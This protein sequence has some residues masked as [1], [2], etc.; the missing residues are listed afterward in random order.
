[1]VVNDFCGWLAGGKDVVGLKGDSAVWLRLNSRA[2]L[3]LVRTFG[4]SCLARPKHAPSSR[5][6]PGDYPFTTH[7]SSPLPFEKL[8]TSSASRKQWP[9]NFARVKHAPSSRG[10]PAVFSL[11]S[12]ERVSSLCVAKEKAPRERPPQSDALRAPCPASSRS[13]C[14]VCRQSILGLTPNWLASMRATLRAFLRHF[15]AAQG[16]RLLRILSSKDEAESAH[17]ARPLNFLLPLTGR[18]CPAGRMR[19]FGFGFGAH[20]A[21]YWGPLDRGETAKEKSEGWPTRCGPVRRQSRDGLS[22]NPVAGSRTWSTGTVRKAR[23]WGGLLF[24]YFLLVTQEKV[25]RSLEASEKRQGCRA[26]KERA[27]TSQ[28]HR[29]PA[30]AGATSRMGSELPGGN[31]DSPTMQMQKSIRD[32]LLMATSSTTCSNRKIHQRG[33]VK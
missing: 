10:I 22:A 3:S 14:G 21:R 2:S 19:G 23:M 12:S 32:I 24:G 6:V 11:A 33:S 8:K 29:A 17:S 7:R 26:P 18:R 13:D 1:M 16:A 15:A 28:R 9:S 25:T 5:G 4:L 30:C 31:L 20:E 27:L